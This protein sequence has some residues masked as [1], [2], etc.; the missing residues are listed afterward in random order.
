MTYGSETRPLLVDVGLKFERAEM[1]MIRWMCGISLKD[2]RTNEELRRLVGV[3]PIT[4]FNRSGRLRWY[5]HVMRKGDEDWVKKCMEYRVEGR[6]PVGRPRKTWLESVEED[7][8][9]L[10][11]D[12]EDVHDRSKWRRNVN[13]EEVQPY[14][15]TDYKPIIYIL[16]GGPPNV[17]NTTVYVRKILL[18][19]VYI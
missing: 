9:E 2:R 10:E 11:I 19:I 3:E 8:A 16:I 12:K 4:T 1:Q 17:R 18:M 5:G 14:R 6:I 13:E 7:M 15:K